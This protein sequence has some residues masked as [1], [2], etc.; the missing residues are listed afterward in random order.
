[1]KRQMTVEEQLGLYEENKEKRIKNFRDIIR[2]SLFNKDSN[3]FKNVQPGQ[4]MAAWPEGP[5]TYPN[6]APMTYCNVWTYL[7]LFA[8]GFKLK[9][10]CST[11]PW[12]NKPSAFFTS[13]NNFIKNAE[14]Q[15]KSLGTAREVDFLQAQN[16][17]ALGVPVVIVQPEKP[18]INP[19]LTDWGHMGLVYIPEKIEYYEKDILIANAGSRAVYGITTCQ[20]SFLAYG[21]KPR[22]FHIIEGGL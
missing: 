13:I 6:G 15:D 7:V 14:I 5:T 21:Y 16:F 2:D 4:A 18:N 17:A 3:I 9:G 12:E 20:K 1:M 11:D 10:L 22:Y 19:K 8:L